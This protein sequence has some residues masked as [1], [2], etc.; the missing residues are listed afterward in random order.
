MKA[1]KPLLYTLIFCVI[2]TYTTSCEKIKEAAEFDL[3]YNV[4][5]VSFNVDSTAVSIAGEEVIALE[6]SIFIDV[7]SLNRR[8]NLKKIESA[9]F[10]FIRLQVVSPTNIN[11]NWLKSLRATLRAEGMPET[12][13]ATYVNEGEQDL[14]VDMVQNNSNITP[15]LLKKQFY[16]RIYTQFNPPLPVRTVTML[17]NSRIRI[18]VQP[19]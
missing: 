19:L 14:I 17:M 11:L 6:T 7:D 8:H 2:A 18:T 16:L 9:R 4:P 3:L 13:I 10:D 1:L 15:F 5:E 12:E